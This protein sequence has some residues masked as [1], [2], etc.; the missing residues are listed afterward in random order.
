MLC[1]AFCYKQKVVDK[2]SKIP[3]QNKQ[4]DHDFPYGL[5][6]CIK[7]MN[8]CLMVWCCPLVR[9]AHTNDVAQVCGFWETLCCM[10]CSALACGMGPC[11]L[12]VYF[13]IHLKDHLGLEDHCLND[14]VLAFCCLPCITGQQGLSVDYLGGYTVKCPCDVDIW[15]GGQMLKSEV[16]SMMGT[17][18][19]GLFG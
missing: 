8:M 7:D 13:R 2:V 19:K 4:Y 18:N 6:D 3:H 17:E 15:G 14:M 16:K 1:Y 12:N 9:I 5:C 11:C 10:G